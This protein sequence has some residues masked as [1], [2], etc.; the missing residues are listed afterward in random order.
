MREN[1]DTWIRNSP[2]AQGVYDLKW[3]KNNLHLYSISI[4]QCYCTCIISLNPWE[5][6]LLKTQK[7]KFYC[8]K[9]K[10]LQWIMI[11][12]SWVCRV[13]LLCFWE[14]IL[15]LVRMWI[16]WPTLEWFMCV[17]LQSASM[18]RKGMSRLG[19]KHLARVSAPMPSSVKN[20]H[21]IYK[22]A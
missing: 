5:P 4:L 9:K 6:W 17:N 16:Y 12:F 15:I 1:T 18:C 11:A 21:E 7:L 22:G 3:V 20:R 14:H 2:Q 10:G 19:W 13:L 8:D